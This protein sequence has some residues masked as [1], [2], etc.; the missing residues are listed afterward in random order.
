MKVHTPTMVGMALLLCFGIAF[1]PNVVQAATLISDDFEVDTSADYTVVDDGTPDGTV[2]FAFD[3]VAAGIP[4][5]PNSQPGDTGGLRFT[6]NDT[7]G[8][9][10][11]FTAFHNVLIP[12][13]PRVTLTVDVYMGFDA[14]ATTEYAHIG[15]G[16]NGVNP[17]T[18]FSPISGSGT[19]VAF[20]GDGGSG[21]SDYRYFVETQTTTTTSDPSYLA[22]SGSNFAQL[23]QDIYPNTNGSPSN[24][25]TTVTVEWINGRIIYSL[26]G[27]PIIDTDLIDPESHSY[28]DCVRHAHN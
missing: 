14:G 3:Y 22:G 20:T 17:N 25:W 26:D 19:F 8:A 24:I 10:D 23:Y 2:T 7:A 1:A 11:A 6:A 16:G 15:I 21:S 13:A 27:T 5:A 18:V 28:S 12:D 4:L 9:S